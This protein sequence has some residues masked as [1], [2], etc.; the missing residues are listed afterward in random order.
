MPMD[1]WGMNS[2]LKI[3]L[4]Q[5]LEN[6][7]IPPYLITSIMKNLMETMVYI[8]YFGIVGWEPLELITIVLLS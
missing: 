2:I 3:F 6:G 5:L 4:R 1:I 7:L 8:S